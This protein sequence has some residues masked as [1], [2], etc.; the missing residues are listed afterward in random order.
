MSQLNL[1]E[2]IPVSVADRLPD[3]D[4]NVLLL[5]AD[6]TS[7]EGFLDTDEGP[8][9]RDVTAELLDDGVVTHWALLPY[10]AE[11]WA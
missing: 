5:L 9:W 1:V 6:G 7:C 11:G 3:V 10:R 2:L 4:T 8:A